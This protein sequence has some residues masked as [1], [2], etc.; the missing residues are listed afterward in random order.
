[1]P[2]VSIIVPVYNTEQYLPRCIDSIL[3]QTFTDFELILVNDGSTDNSGKICDEY[4]LIDSRI[5]VVHRENGG[6]NRAR[7]TGVKIAKGTWIMFVDSDDFIY[8]SSLAELVKY[9]NDKV[10]II[11]GQIE[12]NSSLIYGKISPNEY[13]HLI[14]NGKIFPGPV[15]KLFRYKLF[16]SDVFNL[17]S[18]I[19]IGEDMLMNIRLSFQ[20]K[21]NVII[22]PKTIYKYIRRIDGTYN[23]FLRSIKYE[24]EF[25]QNLL[26]SI[27]PSK[28]V[29]FEQD[30]FVHAYKKYSDFCGY[31]VT[32][33]A[34]WIN[35]SMNNQIKIGFYKYKNLIPFIDRV[36]F[37]AKNQLIRFVLISLK[38]INNQLT[39][40][41][42]FQ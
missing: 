42:K 23:S 41:L 36:L 12:S 34:D 30:L 39:K 21:N 35:T 10:D 9:T 19:I 24:D 2:K 7:E 11:I 1:M 26:K 38:K 13:Q 32:I 27:P 37:C 15:A 18:N 40:C 16:V 22:I 31:R 14:F 25:F 33:L 6:A 28:Y 4:A 5:A 20:L 29:E 3:A 17:H 8:K